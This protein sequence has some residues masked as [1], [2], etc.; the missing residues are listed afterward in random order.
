[1][2]FALPFPL[3]LPLG[4]SSVA[5]PPTPSVG[6]GK[7]SM[8]A[9][10]ASTSSAAVVLRSAVNTFFGGVTNRVIR[11]PGRVWAPKNARTSPTVLVGVKVPCSIDRSGRRRRMSTRGK[12]A[13][14]AAA[15]ASRCFLVTNAPPVEAAA[16]RDAAAARSSPAVGSRAG[17]SAR[18]LDRAR[19]SDWGLAADGRKR[20]KSRAPGGVAPVD[21]GGRVAVKPTVVLPPSFL[22]GALP[23]PES[24]AGVGGGGGSPRGGGRRRD[25]D[26]RAATR[27]GRRG[28]AGISAA[29][30]ASDSGLVGR[31][32]VCGATAIRH[33]RGGRPF[34]RK[35]KTGYPEKDRREAKG[36]ALPFNDAKNLT[37][38]PRTEQVHLPLGVLVGP[39]SPPTL[40]TA[41]VHAAVLQQH[42]HEQLEYTSTVSCCRWLVVKDKQ[43]NIP[44]PPDVH[45]AAGLP[46]HPS[47][48]PRP[49]QLGAAAA[50]AGRPP[51]NSAPPSAAGASAARRQRRRWGQDHSPPPPPPPSQPPPV[52]VAAMAGATAAAAA[53]GEA[54]V[55]LP[56]PFPAPNGGGARPPSDSGGGEELGGTAT[57]GAPVNAAAA[58]ARGRRRLGPCHIARDG[59][60]MGRER[61]LE[62][63]NRMCLGCPVERHRRTSPQN[64]VDASD[65]I[66]VSGATYGV[67]MTAADM[68]QTRKATESA[69]RM[70]RTEPCPKDP[71]Q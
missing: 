26:R 25:A 57:G 54:A 58:S 24:A 19:M 71:Q 68:L 32:D 34:V 53:A 44:A 15:A 46:S 10:V 31:R 49:R 30:A 3:P 33:G 23:L 41:P 37:V 66:D 65:Q 28:G 64:T 1:M 59:R 20:R 29:A 50:A 40:G 70:L 43:T 21:G 38:L 22:G 11:T 63:S 39:R 51:S 55:A 56:A 5:A 42:T 9:T 8:R 18:A 14:R 62:N 52:A 47:R 67:R 61:L 27:L 6:G 36:G 12:R 17:A 35:I 69:G 7:S 60:T 48:S 45:T 16:D 13:M 4:G 2:A